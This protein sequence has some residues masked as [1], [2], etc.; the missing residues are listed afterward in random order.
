MPVV[1]F[2]NVRSGDCSIIKH[3]SGRISMIDVNNA[4]A[5]SQSKTSALAERARA[6]TRGNFGQK[7]SP[8]NPIEYMQRRKLTSIFRFILTHPD[9]DHM[10]GI[11]ALFDEFSPP[12][13]WD[14]ANTC[15]KDTDDWSTSPYDEDDWTFYKSLRD[16]TADTKR[17]VYH[18]NESRKNF[19]KDDG[20]WVLAP[21]EALITSANEAQEWNDSSYVILYKTA[22]GWKILFG[23]DSHD[24]TWE[25][26][27]EE[28]KDLVTYIDVFIAPHHGRDSGRDFEFLDILKPKLTLFG[29][30]RSEHLAYDAWNSRDLPIITN[31]QAGTV[32]VD[33]ESDNEK[34]DV[35]VTNETFARKVNSF[36]F[37]SSVHEGAWYYGTVRSE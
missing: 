27:L 20:L 6:A 8:E 18:S 14:T 3:T 31:N 29:N 16:G 35:Y 15:E 30:A 7:S 4:A 17:L 23:G 36:T 34:G 9:M 25:H 2:L 5:V 11:E 22:P 19:W 1:H 26:I 13:F 28:H 24:A 33:L 37:Q 12:N 32:I 21:S 10:D